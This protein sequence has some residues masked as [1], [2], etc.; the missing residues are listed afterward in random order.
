ML[1]SHEWMKSAWNSIVSWILSLTEGICFASIAS[2]L[3]RHWLVLSGCLMA[4]LVLCI[5]GF[6]FH[7]VI[8]G[9]VSSM[10]L[11]YLGW[12]IG[13]GI[14]TDSISVPA[15][16]AALLAVAGFFTCYLLYFLPVFSGGWSFFLAA[17]APLIG[18]LQGHRLWIAAILAAVYSAFYIKYKLAMSAVTGALGLGLLV[19]SVSPGL[20]A[21]TACACSVGGICLQL[22]LRKQYEIKRR[23][24]AQKQIEKYPYGPGL[25]YGWTEPG[26]TEKS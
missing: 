3:T 1:I 7:K 18:L 25:A 20:G 15:I 14:N 24:E 9:L 5:F 13:C 16:Y 23:S 21:V 4:G 6:R 19:C 26:S 12:H 22:K 8:L 2:A 17:L 10:L 11:G